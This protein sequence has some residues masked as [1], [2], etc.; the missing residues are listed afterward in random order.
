MPSPVIVP[1]VSKVSDIVKSSD[2]DILL[3]VWDKSSGLLKGV[4]GE[5]GDVLEFSTSILLEDKISVSSSE[6]LALNT[7]PKELVAAPGTGK[8]IELISWSP[9]ITFNTTPYA[10]NTNLIVITDTAQLS[11]GTDNFNNEKILQST[12]DRILKLGLGFTGLSSVTD[13][14]LIEDKALTLSVEGGNPTAGDSSIII[15]FTYRVITL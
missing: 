13:K 7:T 3:L 1:N 10:T 2:P 8:A 5:S 15:Y 4:K 6:I 11:Q 9:S 12:G 14:Q